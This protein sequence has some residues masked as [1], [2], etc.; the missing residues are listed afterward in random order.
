ME[1][2]DSYNAISE[3]YVDSVKGIMDKRQWGS[4]ATKTVIITTTKRTGNVK[5]IVS[6]S[7]ETEC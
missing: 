3:S 7:K 5:H 1:K 6:F 2:G 4:M